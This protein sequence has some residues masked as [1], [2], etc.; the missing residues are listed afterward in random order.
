MFSSIKNSESGFSIIETLVVI[1]LFAIM[2]MGIAHSIIYSTYLRGRSEHNATASQLANA[3]MEN[4]ARTDPSTLTSAN[5]ATGAVIQNGV[6]FTRTV[7]VTVQSD[8][9]RTIGVAITCPGCRLGGTATISSNFPQ[10][11]SL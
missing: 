10:W 8:G 2:S 6:T 7:T 4:F 9:S 1:V 5:N 11:G 3:A